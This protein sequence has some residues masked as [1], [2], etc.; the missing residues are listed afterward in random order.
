M[1]L[2]PSTPWSSCSLTPGLDSEYPKPL[3]LLF[4]WGRIWSEHSEAEEA[5]NRASDRRSI[6]STGRVQLTVFMGSAWVL[7]VALRNMIYVWKLSSWREKNSV[8][9]VNG[10]FLIRSVKS[11]SDN[12]GVSIQT[13]NLWYR[14]KRLYSAMN[15]REESASIP[16]LFA[17][18]IHLRIVWWKST[19]DF[20]ESVSEA[21]ERKGIPRAISVKIFSLS[22]SGSGIWSAS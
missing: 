10:C 4:L 12:D 13:L 22:G 17:T 6:I 20:K 11:L 15:G 16:L 21:Y 3:T 14:C 2:Q 1:L 8:E 18:F 7:A 5:G 19:R 9:N